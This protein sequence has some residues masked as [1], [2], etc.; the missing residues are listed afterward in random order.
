MFSQSWPRLRNVAAVVLSPRSAAN[1]D[2]A[3]SSMSYSSW[4]DVV[5]YS[6]QQA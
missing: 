2:S 1:A 6:W 5:A 4:V 3:K